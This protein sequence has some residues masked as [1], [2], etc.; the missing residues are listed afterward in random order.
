MNLAAKSW[1]RRWPLLA[2]LTSASLL[3]GA[4][5]FQYI[6]GLTPCQMCYWQRHA[7]KAVL[8]V[9]LTVMIAQKLRAGDE[10]FARI[11]RGGLFLIAMAFL[12]SAGMGVWHMGVEYGWWEGPK[13]CAVTAMDAGA[14]NPNDFL[15][16]LSEPIKAPACSDV[17]WSMLGLSMAGWN[18]L[19]SALAALISLIAATRKKV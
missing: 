14:F 17:A 1:T 13:T 10:R 5:A 3:G 2:F 11:F 12:V 6:G 8:V 18:A 19:V 15:K 16:S 4:Y 9:S 7:H